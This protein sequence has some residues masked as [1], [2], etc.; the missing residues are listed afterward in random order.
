MWFIGPLIISMEENK[1][2]E[3]IPQIGDTLIV[4]D[5]HKENYSKFK[6]WYT[7]HYSSS[8]ALLVPYQNRYEG[9]PRINFQQVL[10]DA[11]MSRESEV[12]D[13]KRKIQMLEKNQKSS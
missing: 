7:D 10:W 2:S 5:H 3:S 13:L 4:S 9:F 8:G 1:M 6:D 11:Y 12:Q